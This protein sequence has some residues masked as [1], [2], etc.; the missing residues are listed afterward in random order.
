MILHKCRENGIAW[1]LFFSVSVVVA[2]PVLFFDVMTFDLDSYI[3]CHLAYYDRNTVSVIFIFVAI[4]GSQQTDCSRPE[5]TASES[6][7]GTSKRL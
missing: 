7:S 6:S 4:V 3:P 2:F 1:Y 5:P